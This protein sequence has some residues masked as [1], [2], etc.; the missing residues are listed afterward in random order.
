[1]KKVSRKLTCTILSMSLLTVMAGAAIAPALG[2]IR[3]HFASTPS[4]VVQLIISIP[5]LS[6]IIANLCFTLLCQHMRTRAIATIGLALYVA[7]GAGCF[8][9]DNLTTLLIFRVTLGFSVGMI[10]PLSTGLL[11]FYYPPDEQ[12]S[13]MGLAAAM[14]QLGGVVA[15]LLAGILASVSWNY[16][17]LVYIIGVIAIVLV[18]LYLPNE[19]L[20]RPDTE[21][22]R[23]KIENLRR[24]HPSVTGML[25]LM[26]LFFVFPTNF[27]VTTHNVTVLST[28][29]ITFLMVGL[30]VIAFFIGLVFGWLMIPFRRSMKYFAPIGFGL[31][32]ACLAFGLTVPW[33][34]AGCALIGIATGV[35]VPY[36][37]TIA[38]IKGGKDAAMTVMP[39]LSASL[40]LGQFL[41]PLV[42]TPL[43]NTCFNAEIQ[44]PYKIALFVAALYL[45]QVFLTRRFQSL[46]P[47]HTKT[48]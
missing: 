43:A 33:L 25:L 24:F 13:L 10:M 48:T 17:F 5:A 37:N 16:A 15:T 2:V 39:L 47:I 32:Y 21:N 38:S 41:S 23:T 45:L 36:L 9:V 19:Q 42:V 40:Y 7:A 22:K 46:P 18:L 20:T 11:A 14:N 26:T 30:D 35:G 34:V 4:I 1:M 44:G 29:T 12:A 27:A 6:I 3:Q 31:G 8:F 28:N